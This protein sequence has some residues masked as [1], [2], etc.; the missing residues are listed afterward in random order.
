MILDYSLF[1]GPG[2]LL[3]LLALALLVVSVVAVVRSQRSKV[4]AGHETIRG[5]IGTART[6][7]RPEGTVFLDGELW[8]AEVEGT[9]LEAG[10]KV[11]VTDSKGLRLTVRKKE[12]TDA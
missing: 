5:K 6:A 1:T 3:G 7:L 12:E 2:I 9:H 8:Q 4:T 10:S 11:V